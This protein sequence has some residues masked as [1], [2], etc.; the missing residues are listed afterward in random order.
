MNNNNKLNIQIN[1][2][3]TNQN[4]FWDFDIQTDLELID[5]K[6]KRTCHQVHFAIPADHR[7]KPKISKNIC[8]RTKNKQTTN[9]RKN[10]RMT[11][12]PSVVGALGKEKKPRM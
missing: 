4:L 12:I 11:V 9:K 10:M 3:Y 1:D 6:K 8:Q 5:K 2:I 7:K